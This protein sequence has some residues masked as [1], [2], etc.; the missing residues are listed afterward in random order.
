MPVNLKQIKGIKDYLSDVHSG[1]ITQQRMDDT[2]RN[3]TFEI[4]FLNKGIPIVRTGK[5]HRMASA[6][7]EHIITSNPQVFRDARG[8][9]NQAAE[10]V[11]V[12]LNRWARLLLRQNPQPFK[13]YVKKLLGKGEAWSYWFHNNN[14]KKDD[15]NSLPFELVIPDPTI[16]FVDPE[17]GEIDG[18]PNRLIVSYER[19]ASNVRRNYPKWAW[20][21]R[22]NRKW[23]KTV[24]FFMYFDNDVRYWEADG[25]PLILDRDGGLFNG[26]GIQP[27]LYGFV[28]FVHSYSGFGEGSPD[29]NPASLAIGRLTKVRDLIAEYTAIRSVIDYL[30]YKYA[31]PA[32]DYEYDVTLIEEVPKEISTE[33]SRAP[34]AFNYVPVTPGG[35]IKK[36][37]D[38]LPDQA[39]FQ[40]MFNI[41]KQINEEDPLGQIGQAVGTSGRQ[42]DI[43]NEASLRRY[44]T[45]VENTAH[46]FATG[47]GLVM[48][49]MEKIRSIYP[50]S[51]HKGDIG[52]Y[53]QCDIELKAEDP[54]AK[55]RLRNLGS[56]LYSTGEI[57]IE[58]NLT[59]YQGYTQEEAQ[60][61]MAKTLVDNVMRND[62]TMSALMGQQLAKEA[63]FEEEFNA[64]KAQEAGGEATSKTRRPDEIQTP[65]GREEIDLALSQRGGR[66]SPEGI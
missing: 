39:L 19:V 66:R 23:S 34:G 53:Y 64:L 32:L 40:Y 30:T 42:D 36:S 50:N 15:P 47:F 9:A 60:K 16:V 62:P 12:E 51:L 1:R 5:G 35:G 38:M 10:R 41:D 6:P 54:I 17:A 46:S 59:I 4:D 52:K 24:P 13:E 2:Y 22:G 8:N 61:I 44:D 11:S 20:T 48:R 18:V 26:T 31:Y 43:A 28:P 49:M 65:R 63:G 21:N 7:A 14:Y 37:V 29:G 57:D 27:N 33:Y 55:D 25:D 58:T 56:K 3:D 45:I